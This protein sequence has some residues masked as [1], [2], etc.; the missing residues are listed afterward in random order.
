[1]DS[2]PDTE[3]SAAPRALLL[4]STERGYGG[5]ERNLELLVRHLPADI[6]VG[7]L[8]QSPRHLEQLASIQRPGLQVVALD[9]D[10][11]PTDTRALRALLSLY[12]AVRPDAVLVNT[13]PGAR[14]MREAVRWLPEI[15][16][17]TFL[18]IHD[19]L[20]SEMV[21]GLLANLP[22]ASVLVP[23]RVV[24]SGTEALAPE[25]LPW[26][27]CAVHVVPNMAE[28]PTLAS[29]APADE[30]PVLHL[31]N[32]N[33]LKGHT[34]LIEA[35]AQLKAKGIPLSIDSWGASQTK[36]PLLEALQAQIDSA[37]LAEHFR[38]RGYHSNP[39]ELYRDCL[40]VVISS[41]S[42][43]GGPET[44]GRTIIEAWAH[45]RAVVA[46]SAGAPSRLIRHMED[47]LLVREGDAAGLAAALHQLRSDRAL[48]ER[49]ASNGYARWLAS[50]TPEKILRRLLSL[51]AA[52]K[53]EATTPKAST[54]RRDGPPS[55]VLDVS[56]SLRRAH[57]Q[58]VGLAR[59]EHEVLEVLQAVPAINL[60]FCRWDPR[61]GR[62]RE[63][64][65]AERQW[66][67][68]GTLPP[69][70]THWRPEAWDVAATAAL[71][72]GWM[73]LPVTHNR[74]P[75]LI[76]RMLTW[77]G[78]TRRDQRLSV[79]A[80]GLP[81]ASDARVVRV[82]AAN[83]WMAIP[84]QTMV[85]LKQEGAALVMV[86]HDVLT[87]EKPHLTA[88][89][90]VSGFV[91]EMLRS[92]CLADHV[93]AV[94]R[95]SLETF[96]DACKAHELVPPPASVC[97][98]SVPSALLPGA[99]ACAP[100]GFVEGEAFA[101]VCSTL[102]VR[103]NHFLLLNLWE[104]LLARLGPERAPRLVFVGD[105]GWGVDHLRLWLSRD[106]RL[107][108]HVLHLPQLDDAGLAYLY[109]HAR[110]TLFPSFAEGY[111]MPVAESLAAGT[112][113]ITGNHP[114]LLEASQGLMPALDPL[115]LPAWERTVIDLLENPASLASLQARA[116]DYEMQAPGALGE[117]IVRVARSLLAQGRSQPT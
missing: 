62:L 113:V 45:R 46:F 15:S 90:E 64:S 65:S 85:R 33:P 67:E 107:A 76:T 1:M 84:S 32:V 60:G 54:A 25:V 117:E 70:N 100:P 27:R 53:S 20:W 23:D 36:E 109:R 35:A 42:H 22:G 7:V 92:L 5:A 56:L 34:H 102:E 75:A 51:L 87:W 98:P 88:G 14:L 79:Q 52:R 66:M 48:R 71:G 17:Q 106:W 41:V 30:S 83:P 3:P 43:S 8:A 68:F 13:R 49:L 82:F 89:R 97:H 40:C 105:W 26:G 31:A 38:L 29:L 81:L 94:S 86:L 95:H 104:R 61:E 116:K 91:A 80:A 69:Q 78:V 18:Y 2:K 24:I 111:G 114:A 9:E 58:P 21:Q 77:R 4:V 103:K 108:G 99:E 10:C 19:F 115:D 63:L 44:F 101:L 57:R 110:F 59:V 28:A 11:K 112:P 73:T 74:P 12:R 96:R 6:R 55:V 72:Q 37:G 16:Q 50:Y 93:V 47:G 39:S